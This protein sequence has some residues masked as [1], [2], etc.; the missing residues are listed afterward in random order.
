MKNALICLL[1]TLTVSGCAVD[2]SG[3][4][5][6]GA[7]LILLGGQVLTLLDPEPD[8]A[9]TAVAIR[10]DR[11]IYVGDDA[12]ARAL[13]TATTRVVELA[14]RTVVPGFADSHAHLYG[15]GKALAEIDLV[16]TASATEVVDAVAA[17]AAAQPGPGWLQGRGWD[18]N[19]WQVAVFPDRRL[20]DAVA[21]DRPVFLRRIDGHAAWAN[22]AALAAAGISS[23][24]GDPAGGAILRDATAHSQYQN[25][26]DDEDQEDPF[27]DHR[28]ALAT[29]LVFVLII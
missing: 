26:G 28:N 20:L 17:A 9:P 16:G 1:A 29:K 5:G 24:T 8:P 15:L 14:G 6:P 23:A 11:I 22:S 21:P 27:A 4:E 18:Q 10:A 3:D 7:D 25:C 2:R 12:G 13:Q 19:D